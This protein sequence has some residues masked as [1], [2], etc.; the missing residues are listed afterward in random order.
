MGRRAGNRREHSSCGGAERLLAATGQRLEPPGAA[1]FFGLFHGL[2]FA[3]GL[4]DAMRELQ[5]GTMFL[6]IVA[7][8]LGVEAGHQMVVLP[9]FLLLKAARGACS[10]VVQR[11]RLSLALQRI[12]SAGI[13]VAGVYYLIAAVFLM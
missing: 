4:L 3:G 5:G 6:A 9:T 12:G 2:G 8:S 11:T 13:A 1:F 7:F 10:D